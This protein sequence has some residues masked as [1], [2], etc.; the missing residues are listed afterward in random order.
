MAI[1]LITRRNVRDVYLLVVEQFAWF[2]A[3]QGVAPLASGKVRYE[4]IGE[5][6]QGRWNAVTLE[7]GV[8][9]CVCVH[10][11]VLAFEGGE[12]DVSILV[13]VCVC[14]CVR[15][16]CVCM[17]ARGVCVCPVCVLAHRHMRKFE[18]ALG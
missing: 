12:K 1:I 8:F 18:H 15:C 5:G 2:C 7:V 11:C 16:V 9:A 4:R 13:R 14:V 10:V 3:A 6:K 17:C